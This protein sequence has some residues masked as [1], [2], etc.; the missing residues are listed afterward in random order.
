MPRAD[1]DAALIRKAK[2]GELQAFNDLILAYQDAVYRQAYWILGEPE[3]AEDAAQE[4]FFRAYR[5]IHT[6][7]GC[8]FR[9]WVLRIVTNYAFDQLRRS[10]VRPSLP[11]EMLDSGEDTSRDDS[12]WLVDHAP[13]PEEAVEQAAFNRHITEC[14]AKLTPAMRLPIILVDIQEMEYLEA[15]TVMGLP[16]GTFKSRL[17][18][19]RARLMQLIDRS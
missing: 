7:D 11:L 14:L 10:K 3:A 18:R 13:T 19:A 16:L 6:Y 5:K 8:S 15:A 1:R 4:A 12:R 17:S 9:A 2:Q